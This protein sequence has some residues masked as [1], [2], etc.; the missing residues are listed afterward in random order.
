MI[1]PRDCKPQG[2]PD[3]IIY[4]PDGT[5]M[6]GLVIREVGMELL[7]IRTDRD[8]HPEAVV[9]THPACIAWPGQSNPR[10]HVDSDLKKGWVG[11]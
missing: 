4:F 10:R 11:E 8:G 2:S 1:D 9:L 7:C 6:V 3:T 5:Q